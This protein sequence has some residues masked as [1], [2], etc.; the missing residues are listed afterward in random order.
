MPHNDAE[1]LLGKARAAYREFST[2]QDSGYVL[3]RR[4]GEDRMR[5]TLP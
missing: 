3:Q 2:Y 4:S 1:E 5:T